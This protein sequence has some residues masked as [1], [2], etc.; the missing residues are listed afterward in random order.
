M[1]ESANNPMPTGREHQP[2]LAVLGGRSG[3]AWLAL[4]AADP[5][6]CHVLV[7][8]RESEVAWCCCGDWNG[9]DQPLGASR[10]V[11]CG[12]ELRPLQD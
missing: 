9:R 10:L 6:I 2:S 8:G 7:D 5:C 1:R 11:T 3:R 12:P 4:H